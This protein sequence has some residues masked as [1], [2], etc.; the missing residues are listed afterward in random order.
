MAQMAEP[1]VVL[2]LGSKG[3]GGDVGSSAPV[4]V[5]LNRSQLKALVGHLDAAA[6]VVAEVAVAET[7]SPA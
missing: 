3:T 7:A 2:T 1:R 6:E 4:V 5:E